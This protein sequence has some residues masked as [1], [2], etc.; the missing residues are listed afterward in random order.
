MAH[1]PCGLNDFF[2][3]AIFN[4]SLGRELEFP[5]GAEFLIDSAI[6]GVDERRR[7][8]EAEPSSILRNAGFTGESYRAGGE[9]GVGL[10]GEDLGCC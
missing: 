1:P 3:E 6:F 2:G 8:E 9:P 5:I 4:G 10:V 7:G